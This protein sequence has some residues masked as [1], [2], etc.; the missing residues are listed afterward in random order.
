M[1][2]FSISDLA[3]IA[4]CLLPGPMGMEVPGIRLINVSPKSVLLESAVM[5]EAACDI[6]SA[7]WTADRFPVVS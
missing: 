2:R 1:S 3:E 5:Q 7:D 4:P 6:R